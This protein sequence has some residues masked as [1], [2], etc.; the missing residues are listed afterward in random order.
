M[1]LWSPFAPWAEQARALLEPGTGGHFLP[2]DCLLLKAALVL[3]GYFADGSA[4]G[5]SPGV[6]DGDDLRLLLLGPPAL[7]LPPANGRHD[8]QSGGKPRREYLIQEGA[9]LVIAHRSSARPVSAEV[10]NLA[11][12]RRIADRTARR[13]GRIRS[14][15]RGTAGNR[16]DHPHARPSHQPRSGSRAMHSSSSRAPRARPLVPN[17]LRAGRCVVKK[18]T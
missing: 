4:I 13:G 12:H 6:E 10:E 11:D 5:V 3:R 8:R 7:P 9:P 14:R 1:S 2:E 18:V 16:A 15:W 17:A